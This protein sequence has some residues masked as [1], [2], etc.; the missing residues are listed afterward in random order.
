MNSNEK[1][2]DAMIKNKV[3]GI[4]TVPLQKSVLQQERSQCHSCSLHS[5][6]EHVSGTL[7]PMA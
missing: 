6:P 7:Q 2:K 1:R 3:P 5:S 4:R